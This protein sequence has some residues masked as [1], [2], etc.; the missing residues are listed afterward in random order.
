MYIQ[1]LRAQTIPSNGCHIACIDPYIVHV[2]KHMAIVGTD[3]YILSIL[4]LY[5]AKNND[6]LITKHILKTNTDGMKSWLSD[7]DIF[8]VDRGLR[9]VSEYLIE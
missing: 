7:N 2:V 4:G 3:G 5:H 1:N 8:I 6:A 9:D